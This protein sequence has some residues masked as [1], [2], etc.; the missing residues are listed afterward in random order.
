MKLPEH[1]QGGGPSAEFYDLRTADGP[2]TPI[3]GDVS[4]YLAQARRTGGPILELACGTGRIAFPLARAGYPVTGVDRA[5]AMLAI[6]RAK[7]RATPVPGLRL[8]R[9]SMTRFAVPGRFALA[10][11]AFR[12]FQHLLT[13]REQRVC[14]VHV[15]RHL[16][17]NGRLVVHLFDPRLEYCVPQM[18][19]APT[20]RTTVRDSATGQDV[21]VAITD[22]RNDPVSQTFSETWNWTI[23]RQGRVIRRHADVMRLRWTYRHE[24]RHLFE[25]T[26]YR[27]LAE[28]SDFNG[29]PP[30]YGAEQVWVVVRA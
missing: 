4:F 21:S 5:P 27:V 11:I 23:A 17:P 7:L 20:V 18:P 9:G 12:A 10:I 6:A 19:T 28:Y 29:S 22:R 3:H 1:F 14:L 2:A 30:R 8:V 13:V 26:G 25:L 15:R 16:R 24:M